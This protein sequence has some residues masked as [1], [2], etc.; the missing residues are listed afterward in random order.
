MNALP[1][2]YQIKFTGQELDTIL[3]QVRF[4]LDQT[5]IANDLKGGAER[6]MSAELI[7]T[8]YSKVRQFLDP[9]EL[10]DLIESIPGVNFL[11]KEMVDKLNRMSEKFRGVYRTQ[12][13]R[14]SALLTEYSKYTGNE[15][16]LILD[17]G[18]SYAKWQVWDI[19]TQTWINVETNGF[20]NFKTIT[21]PVP[22]EGEEQDF[23]EI[24][25]FYEDDYFFTRFIIYMVNGDD[26]EAVNISVTI[27]N[28]G[29]V[30]YSVFNHCG[31]TTTNLRVKAEDLDLGVI[32]IQ[33][34][35]PA[36]S[37]VKSS[38]AAYVIR[39]DYNTIFELDG[40]HIGTVG[41][42]IYANIANGGVVGDFGNVTYNFDGG[43][44]ETTAPTKYN[45]IAEGQP[46]WL[47]RVLLDGENISIAVPAIYGNFYDGNV[48]ALDQFKI[49]GGTFGEFPTDQYGNIF[50]AGITKYLVNKFD[51]GVLYQWLLDQYNHIAD[52]NG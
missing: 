45:H 47:T 44:V 32:S 28:V 35:A 9:E 41:S 40:T 27:D 3:R 17:N 48:P 50:D 26:I 1:E 42:P 19:D 14:D 16:T 18:D 34:L 15:L 39:D 23:V 12:L 31:T 36:G 49:N 33:V 38:L 52:G 6:V 8:L 29:G 24:T 43:D 11:T 37:T 7:K 25:R 2:K 30:A 4:K 20:G 13:E 5:Q 51:G 46:D 21:V 10:K 22:P